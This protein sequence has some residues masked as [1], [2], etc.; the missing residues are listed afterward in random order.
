MTASRSWA[1][2]YVLRALQLARDEAR[3]TEQLDAVIR[4]LRW[5][6][7]AS[8]D[9]ED[10]RTGATVAGEDV[11]TLEN[12]QQEWVLIKA[13][14]YRNAGRLLDMR[15][16]REEKVRLMAEFRRL[17]AEQSAV[18]TGAASLVARIEQYWQTGVVADVAVT[19]R[20]HDHPDASIA[21]VMP[22]KAEDALVDVKVPARR[23]GLDDAFG[24][25]PSDL[26]LP[27]RAWFEAIVRH[28]P[29]KV[30][31]GAADVP[32]TREAHAR[33]T[34]GA[35]AAW[36]TELTV[37]ALGPTWSARPH[38]WQNSGHFSRYYW[39]KVYPTE[40]P[41]GDFFNVGV[42]IVQAPQWI[43]E[44]DD[45]LRHHQDLPTLALWATTNDDKIKR[46]RR[47]KPEFVTH[48]EE[49]Y[50]RNQM[51]AFTSSPE[52]WVEGGALV[53]WYRIEHGK[54]ISHLTTARSFN[55]S[56]AAGRLRMDSSAKNGL[57]SPLLPLSEAIADP[58]RASDLVFT[59]LRVLGAVIADTYGE[60]GNGQTD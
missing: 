3:L 25:T 45:S 12:G 17:L 34:W 30:V 41:L 60:I 40:H 13:P 59:Y 35:I 16:S 48:A 26:P 36:I 11:R 19:A 58:R 7:E 6:L 8:L 31:K 2:G 23:P 49:I 24:V 55:E 21:P 18:A 1:A 37:I 38:Q 29:G 27:D 33:A 15:T 28:V 56:V 53:R 43:D 57:W 9:E 5:F 4:H 14:N 46:R 47:D 32:E 39:G 50:G 52:L 20:S 22:P 10:C 54:P 42:Q 44:F 51:A